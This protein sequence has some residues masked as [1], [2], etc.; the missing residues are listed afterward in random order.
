MKTQLPFFPILRP[1]VRPL[2][3]GLAAGLFAGAFATQ[4]ALLVHVPYDN[5]TATNR[6]TGGSSFN[7]TLQG[8]ATYTT[9]AALGTGAISLD[10]FGSYVSHGPSP[11]GGATNR[12]VSIWTKNSILPSD[13]QRSLLAFGSAAGSP[14]GSKMDFDVDAS[15]APSGVGRLEIGVNGGRTSPNYTSPGVNSNEWTLVTFTWSAS[16]G[17]SMNGGRFFVNGRFVYAPGNASPALN[18]SNGVFSAFA[19]GKSANDPIALPTVQQYFPG[20]LDDVAIWDETL[21]DIE[22]LGLYQVASDP[23]LQYD[24][25]QFQQL[26]ALHQAGSGSVTIGSRVWE[27]ATSLPG[28]GGLTNI[29][30]GTVLVLNTNNS[31]NQTGVAN[32]ADV[33]P[34][35]V[36]QPVSVTN[37]VGTT[38]TL[39]VGALGKGLQYQWYF[40][41]GPVTGA[42]GATLVRDP[43]ALAHHGPYTV[44]VTNQYGRRTSEVATITV[45][46]NTPPFLTAWPSNLTVIKGQPASFSVG[47]DGSPTLLYQWR[48]NGTPQG[49]PLTTNVYSIAATAYSDQGNWDV[50]VTNNFGSVTSTPPALLTVRDVTPPVIANATNL[51][52]ASAGPAGAVVNLAHV[53]AMDDRDGG[54]PV[55]ISPAGPLYPPGISVVT[56]SATD[57]GGNN[58][59]AYFTVTVF[60]GTAL[61]QT[62]FFDNFEVSEYSYDINLG[63]S[64]GRQRGVLAPIA[65]AELA[66]RAQYGQFD[67]LSLVG[68]FTYPGTLYLN[69]SS[70]NPNFAS[71]TPAHEFLES[72]NFAVEFDVNPSGGTGTADWAAVAIGSPYPHVFPD[73]TVNGMGFLFRGNNQITVNQNQQQTLLANYPWSLPTPPYRVRLQVQASA[74]DGSPAIVRGFVNGTPFPITSNAVSGLVYEYVKTNGFVNNYIVLSGYAQNAG[75]VVHTFDNFTVTALPTVFAS[76]SELATVVGRSNQTFLV[77]VP[78]SLVATGAVSVIVSNANPAIAQ[79]LGEAGGLLT[80]DF[81]SGGPSAKLV[82]LVG[83]AAGST[84]LTLRDP[85]VAVAI[86]GKPVTVQV[87]GLPVRILNGSFE[88]PPL[89]AVP[90]YGVIPG[91]A[92]SLTTSNGVSPNLAFGGVIANNSHSSHGRNVGFLQGIGVL[93]AFDGMLSTT[94][95]NLVPGRA[96]EVSFLVN[97]QQGAEA[98]ALLGVLLDGNTRPSA[99]VDAVGASPSG[100]KPVSLVLTAAT[101]TATLAV[102]NSTA[103]ASGLLVDNFEVQELQPQRWHFAP[104]TG[105]ADSGISSASTYT[106]TYNL[107]E[108]VN[109]TLNGVNFTGVGGANPSMPDR[110]SYTAGNVLV[111]NAQNNLTGSSFNLGGAF[112]YGNARL[113]LQGLTPGAT[114]QLRLFGAGF[115]AN[116]GRRVATFTGGGQGLTVD[117]NQFEAGNG[118][119]VTYDYTASS[120]TEILDNR[121]LSSGTFHLWAFANQLVAL[122]VQLTINQVSSTQVRIAWPAAATG[123]QL[124]A[125]A[126]VASGYAN[127]GVTPTLEGNEWVVYQ[128]NT[129]QRFYRLIK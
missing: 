124:Q 120:S 65:Y 70:P 101:S 4:A 86:G 43:L 69:P 71:A 39:S 114:Y 11:L 14:N 99:Q 103:S 34:E 37:V 26:R 48:K 85:S 119:I 67:Y 12:T 118:I 72:P 121:S 56:A 78:P 73:S 61:S 126:A 38:A 93:G 5:D 50:V 49:S 45:L 91:W 29:T 52:V 30:L 53:T 42:T 51:I 94:I 41:N 125:S 40:T 127:L 97:A 35:I 8:S 100:Y 24:A 1:F 36:V 123:Y 27:F 60:P 87:S 3:V 106:H 2:A 62:N 109:V 10:G 77:T 107:G 22:A 19:V 6:G 105:D 32:W 88:E 112:V 90:G 95:S 59:K 31:G 68:D 81:S 63:F 116:D 75:A 18:T 64:A 66:T 122:P 21:A 129:G 82:T 58:V 44:V 74:F 113:T 57:A 25:G 83:L 115:G 33:A 79:M 47:A 89:P 28:V 17:S 110:F 76:P 16:R 13:G 108:A 96:Y 20:L 117:E 46:G 9:D 111:P 98:N 104:W 54:I 80:L 23:A 7:G 15:A 102:S 128:D 84:T 92:D 55:S